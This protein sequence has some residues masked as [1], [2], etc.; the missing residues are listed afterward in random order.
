MN[1]ITDLICDWEI[2][3]AFRELV[4]NREDI[5]DFPDLFQ[6]VV[7]LDWNMFKLSGFEEYMRSGAEKGD[8]WCQYAWAR[9]NDALNFQDNSADIAADYYA[10]AADGGVPDAIAFIARM[11]RRGEIGESNRGQYNNYLEKALEK[12]STMALLFRLNDIVYGDNGQ[13]ADPREAYARATSIVEKAEAEGRHISPQFCTIAGKA[14][15]QLGRSLEAYTWYKQ[16]F[17]SGDPKANFP[18]ARLY[19]G[20]DEDGN[21]PGKDEFVEILRLG[22]AKD[23]PDAWLLPVYF[24]DGQDYDEKQFLASCE[25]AF[26]LGESFGAYVLGEYF[27]T[28]GTAFEADRELAREW[29]GRGARLR[30]NFC[31]QAIAGMDEEDIKVSEEIYG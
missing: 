27:R 24:A 23:V 16:A 14:C 20:M 8:V 22:M 30:D 9:Y 28:G 2:A 15:E 12:G 11:L 1:L 10:K 18:M 19:G 31:I 6:E 29:Y 13:K 25:K 21:I 4:G 7:R 5:P 3:D 26:N 17:N